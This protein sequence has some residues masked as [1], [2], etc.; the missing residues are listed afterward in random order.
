MNQT[1]ETYFILTIQ[2]THK[3]TLVISQTLTSLIESN[4]ATFKLDCD[5]LIVLYFTTCHCFELSSLVISID[6]I[7]ATAP[8]ESYIQYRKWAIRKPQ[9]IQM[10]HYVYKMQHQKAQSNAPTSELNVCLPCSRINLHAMETSNT[11]FK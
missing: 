9:N 10:Y 6:V 11:N 7:F 5:T 3:H 1:F 4:I 8:F 2:I